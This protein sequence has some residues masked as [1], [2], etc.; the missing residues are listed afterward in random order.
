[1]EDDDDETFENEAIEVYAANKRA[2]SINAAAKLKKLATIENVDDIDSLATLTIGEI[3]NLPPTG[4]IFDEIIFNKS[5]CDQTSLGNSST[6]CD[7]ISTIN[8]SKSEPPS[9]ISDFINTSKT[10]QSVQKNN[11][12]SFENNKKHRNKPIRNVSDIIHSFT[13]PKTI[14][15]SLP[16]SDLRSSHQNIESVN[17]RGWRGMVN[18]TSMC[19]KQLL[20]I[21]CPGPSRVHLREHM[22]RFLVNETASNRS[23]ANRTNYRDRYE[24]LV[25]GLLNALEAAKNRSLQ[26]RIVRALLVN[27][28]QT[29]Q[30]L[31]ACY[32]N[33]DHLDISNGRS[34][35]L[36]LK[37]L[38]QVMNPDAN[39]VNLKV[40]RKRIC[41]D[42]VED[43]VKFIL[44]TD[45][46]KTLSWGSIDKVLTPTETI[47]LPKLQRIK[48]RKIMWETYVDEFHHDSNSNK[49]KIGR[50]SF[51]LLCRE[52][53]SC[54]ELVLS[55]VDYVQALL[56]TDSIELLQDIV[57]K[58]KVPSL[59][60]KFTQYLRSLNTFL[61]YQYPKH[62][63]KDDKDD[64]CCTH[65]LEFALGR[66]GSKYDPSK[67][68]KTAS[69]HC[70]ECRFYAF[71]CDSISSSVIDEQYFPQGDTDMVKDVIQ[72]CNGCKSKI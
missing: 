65:G 62:V 68:T 63:I 61:K 4:N 16:K 34:K 48:T 55:S 70:H 21:I 44:S 8:N 59:S 32:H 38:K 20:D 27:G 41:D 15:S 31:R 56:L 28:I 3:P 52:L 42:A 2:A 57:D 54:D 9:K 64:T 24:F 19:C 58:I 18:L 66:P 51:H 50:T 69:I 35:S 22:I 33:N 11:S 71:V 43:A 46:I 45:N 30:E 36:A 7:D 53:T 10:N 17:A 47:V 23:S 37:D 72:A 6:I 13:L 29:Q 60:T 12:S 67:E 5:E 26:K 49:S 1:M 40:S 39:L 14:H 25:K